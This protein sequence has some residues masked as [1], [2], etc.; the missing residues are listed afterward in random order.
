MT[1]SRR[2]L[3]RRVFLSALGLGISAPLALRMS[4]MAVAQAAGRPKRLLIVFIPHGVPVEHYQPVWDGTTLTLTPSG[5]GAFQP[6]GVLAPLQP[7]ASQ[8]SVVQGVSMNDGATNHAAVR[9]ALTGFT[10]GKGSDSIDTIIASAMGVKPWLLGALGYD[11]QQGFNE[12]CYLSKQSAW[13]SPQLDP[14]K[15]ATAMF[16]AAGATAPTVDESVFRNQ[17]LA[18]TEGELDGMAKSL[19]ALT[20]EQTKLQVHLDAIRA[21]KAGGSVKPVMTC[22][23]RPSM[24]TVDMVAGKNVQ[25]IANFAEVLDAHLELIAGAFTCG[26]ANVMV[27][28]A[29]YV[30]AQY[31]MNFTGGPGIADLYHDPTSHSSDYMGRAR[32][33]TVQRW[34]FERLT[35]KLVKVLATTPDMAD[36]TGTRMVLDNTIIMTCSEIA[37]G[38]IHNSQPQKM[39]VNLDGNGTTKQYNMSLPYVFIG[40]GSGYFKQGGQIVGADRM[41][42]D[43][44]ATLADAMGVPITSM[45]GKAVSPIADLK[46]S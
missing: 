10:D 33:A 14:S 17:V 19:S 21:L 29:M 12:N 28:Q 42:I 25:D 46:A 45:G 41:H 5:Q 43:V 20:R 22:N 7:Y 15:V 24:P 11:A 26:A 8:I 37:D 31:R 40:G 1:D 35:T 9:A 13:V 18:L 2:T 34:F 38:F 44:L 30:N 6:V 4:R 23:G 16:G 39:A 3:K 32:F 36:G 27:L